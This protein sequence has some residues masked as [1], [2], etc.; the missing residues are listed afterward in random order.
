MSQERGQRTIRR[1]T[2]GAIM[3]ERRGISRESR[4]TVQPVHIYEHVK[5]EPGDGRLDQ[6]DT[7]NGTFSTVL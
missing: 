1:R 4:L 2:E 5:S 7:N 6:E 3:F